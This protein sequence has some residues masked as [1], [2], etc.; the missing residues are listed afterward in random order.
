[1]SESHVGGSDPEF[2]GVGLQL[3]LVVSHVPS[4]QV[5]VSLEQSL[6]MPGVH[7]PVWQVSDSVQGLPSSQATPVCGAASHSTVVLLHWPLMHGKE[8]S[9]VQSFIVPLQAP[10]S[11]L[12]PLVH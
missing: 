4:A 11:H 8:S 7:T 10:A 2:F 1:M 6:G 3:P 9:A 5:V 12:S